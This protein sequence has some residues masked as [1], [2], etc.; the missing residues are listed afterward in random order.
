MKGEPFLNSNLI[1]FSAKKVRLKKPYPHFGDFKIESNLVANTPEMKG[2]VH[3]IEHFSTNRVT[4]LIQGETGTGK[5]LVAKLI[6]YSGITKN[7]PFIIVNCSGLTENM[8]ESELFG[9]GRMGKLK[10]AG[11]GTLFLDEISD[12]SQNSQAKLLKILESVP[13]KARLI[14]A[15]SRDLRT[16][17]NEGRFSEE[18]YYRLKIL[19]IKIPPLRKR[20]DDIPHLVNHFINRI[21]KIL[22]KEIR[23]TPYEVIE[24]LMRPSWTGNVRELENAIYQAIVLSHSDVLEKQNIRIHDNIINIDDQE[25]SGLSLHEVEREHIQLVLRKVNNDMLK[26]S[27]ILGISLEQLCK[28]SGF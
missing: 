8:L 14:A 7:H 2:I 9:N 25:R 26:A 6:H 20:K 22:N 3:K 12:A 18:L 10:T 23:I 17:V 13:L 19:S 27:K 15:S 21:N 1:E 16:L 11:K 5:K 4:I 24:M 28:I